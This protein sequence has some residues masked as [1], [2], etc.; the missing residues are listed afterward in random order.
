MRSTIGS[1]TCLAI[2]VIEYLG[3][4][5]LRGC[6]T[7]HFQFQLGEC[8]HSRFLCPKFPDKPRSCIYLPSLVVLSAQYR[9]LDKEHLL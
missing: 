1:I 9:V 6:I 3:Y 5:S 2:L 4:T 8:F 7:A